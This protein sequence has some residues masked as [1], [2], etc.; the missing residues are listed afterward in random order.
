MLLDV[1]NGDTHSWLAGKLV[2][3]GPRATWNPESTRLHGVPNQKVDLL[4]RSSRS[5]FGLLAW[6]MFAFGN[7]VSAFGSPLRDV[8]NDDVAGRVDVRDRSVLKPSSSAM[9]HRRGNAAC[10]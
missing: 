3:P 1:C 9:F 5:P 4:A 6:P 10:A 2:I 7:P 8:R